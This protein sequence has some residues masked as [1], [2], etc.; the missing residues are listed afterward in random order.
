MGRLWT[1]LSAFLRPEDPSFS[2]EAPFQLQAYR[3]LTLLGAAL[4]L[5]FAPLYAT[6]APDA[7]DPLWARLGMAGLLGALVP[8]SYVSAHVRAHYAAWM[9]GLFLVTMAWIVV[10]VVT[11]RL[12]GEYATGLLL[13]YAVLTAFVG[14]TADSGRPVA[15]FSG[16]GLLLAAGGIGT[17]VLLDLRLATNPL[18]LLAS[19]AAVGLAQG[20]AIQRLL[21]TQAALQTQKEQLSSITGNVSEGIYRSTPNEGLVYANQAFAEMFGYDS[22]E[23][24]LQADS[25]SFYADPTARERL[26][27]TENREGGL[28]GEEVRFRRPDGTTFIG[29]LNSTVVRDE[30]GDIQ[31]YDGAVTDITERKRREQRLRVL[32]EV[33]EQA[34]DGILV[35]ASRRGEDPALGDLA[36]AP[37]DSG[38]ASSSRN[39]SSDESGTIV[40]ANRAFEEMTG[41]REDELLGRTADLLRGPETDSDVIHSLQEAQRDGTSWE[42]E[43][44]NYRKD[45][46]PYVA[47]WNASPVRDDEGAVEYWASIQRDV[48]DRR[49]MEERLRKQKRRLRGL[50]NS[51]PGVAYQLYARPNGD[52]GCYFVSEHAT[53]MLGLS[54]D[55]DSFHE[56]FAAHIPASHQT[57]AQKQIDQ[58]VEAEQAWRYEIP[59]ETPD[60]DRMWLLDTATPEQRDG[61][62]VFNGVMLDI[63]ERKEMEKTLTYRSRLESK[64]VDISTR[65]INTPLENLDRKVEDALAAVGQFVDADRSYVFLFDDDAKRMKNTHEWQAES[66]AHRSPLQDIPYA[67]TPWLVERLHNRDDALDIGSIDELPPVASGLKDR[68]EAGHVQSLLVLPMLKGDEL[69]GFVGFDAV[70]NPRDW[71]S[72]TVMLLRVLTEAISNALQRKTI[73]TEM[74]AAKEEAEEANRMKSVFL[75]NMSHEIRTPLTSIIGFAEA[76]GEELGP[77]APAPI[78]RFARLIEESGTRL[79]ETLDGVLNLSKLE[80]GEMELSTEVVDLAA[81]AEEMASQLAPQAESAGIDLC[82]ETNDV[83]VPA[84][85]DEGGVQIVLRNLISNAIKYTNDGGTVWVRARTTDDAAVI[86]VEDTGIGMDPEQVPA[87]FEAF[88]QASEG[89]AREYEGTGLGLAVTKQAVDRMDGTIEVET[90]KGEGSHFVVRLPDAA[91]VDE[92]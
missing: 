59:F 64:I 57:E 16:L 46:T 50:A 17:A 78:P 41:Y 48:T 30:H 27:E 31:Y 12:A 81:E 51:L 73:E 35:T 37:R 55:P 84:Q 47:H 90:E 74:I 83:A 19:L 36:F 75:A 63:T 58:A 26:V 85:A 20:L 82:V 66:E 6:S 76:I 40:Y 45:G 21:S 72:D 5:L 15:W 32:S 88:R 4:I 61:E 79:L 10:V 38:A 52:R 49:T 56:Q 34:H 43:T 18:L 77:D 14:M 54:A 11:N 70:R 89:L 1:Q 28:E 62:L 67:E 92:A 39:G 25:A 87:L 53:T 80:S 9:R 3:L 24:I 60:G 42:G 7:V 33:V 44:V 91:P 69:A 65:F 23:A 8:A 13:S 29:L 22:V 68:L 2:S 71:D 86:A